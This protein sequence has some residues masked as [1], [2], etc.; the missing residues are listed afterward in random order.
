MKN[1]L[2][3]NILSLIGATVFMVMKL[4]LIIGILISLLIIIVLNAIS[5][6]N[7]QSNHH[8][9]K[10]YS[11]E[12]TKFIAVNDGIGITN[13][14]IGKA[15]LPYFI[16]PQQARF[17]AYDAH[18]NI[19]NET[20]TETI[21]NPIYDHNKHL[22]Y[23]ES[24]D[25]FSV[26]DY[27]QRKVIKTTKYPFSQH[28]ILDKMGNR[29]IVD[30]L[31]VHNDELYFSQVRD[32]KNN[33]AYKLCQ[34]ETKKCFDLDDK[35]NHLV[36]TPA[37]I[38]AVSNK[39]FWLFD[40][41]LNLLKREK[42][43]NTTQIYGVVA[44]NQSYR[45][46]TN[47]KI[48]DLPCTVL[49][50]ELVEEYQHNSSVWLKTSFVAHNQQIYAII[51]KKDKDQK[52]GGKT[53]L[54]VA[55]IADNDQSQFKSI[56]EKHNVYHTPDMVMFND[57]KLMFEFRYWNDDSDQ[58]RNFLTYEFA[59]HQAQEKTVEFTPINQQRIGYQFW[60]LD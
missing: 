52:T 60:M 10:S 43:D 44:T 45:I 13:V 11:K 9:S 4:A 15:V 42:I 32:V 6:S 21:W 25:G 19:T 24:L 12:A 57:K 16:K 54:Y 55:N 2:T 14:P 17:I 59:N 27:L 39:T 37:G 22:V 18:G 49:S 5:F 51:S 23:Y 33:A 46:I 40:R 53:A 34:V 20:F 7:N 56:W 28:Y 47:R 26:F 3:R 36:S 31:I 58:K 38:V 30:R 29:S 35:L 8:R 1:N 41:N 50:R 48:A